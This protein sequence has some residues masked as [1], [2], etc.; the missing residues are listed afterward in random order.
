[1]KNK[2]AQ[3]SS[4][5]TAR[6]LFLAN[7][8][9]ELRTPIQTIIGTM[10]LLG[11]TQLDSEQNE[12]VRQVRFSADVLLSLVNDFLDF[13]KLESGKFRL[14]YIPYNPL[15]LV[16]Q[17]VDLLA[18]EAYNKKIEIITDIDYSLP[19]KIIGDPTRVQQILLNL[20]KNA[21]KFTPSGYVQIS[22]KADKAKK[23]ITYE[24]KD[25]GIG[26]KKEEQKNLFTDFYQTD[27][28]T[29]RKYGGTGLGLAICKNF[30]KLMKGN[31]GMHDNPDGGSIFSFSLPYDDTGQ[32]E[33]KPVVLGDDIIKNK[34]ILIVDDQKI[35]AE[36]FIKKL[37]FLGFDSIEAVYSGEE[38]LDTMLSAVNKGQPFTDVFIDMIMPN[39]DGWRLSAEINQNAI[40]NNAKLFLLIPEGQMDGEAKMK[41]LKW[42]NSY[43]HKPIK[44]D[45][46]IN[47]LVDSAEDILELEVVNQDVEINTVKSS[48]EPI[49]A[50]RTIL[51]AEDHPVN[52]KLIKTFF[53]QFGANVI[54]AGNGEE[55][56]NLLEQNPNVDLVFMDIQ[57]PV[58]SGIDATKEIRAKGTQ[59]PII[60][61]TANT[62]EADFKEYFAV[63]MNDILLK[64]FKKKNVYEL[65]EKWI[66]QLSPVEEVQEV[67]A[68]PETKTQLPVWDIPSMQNMLGYDNML[69]K[70]LVQQFLIQSMQLIHSAEEAAEKHDFVQI[71]KNAEILEDSA[72]VLSAQRIADDAK[73]LFS[74][75]EKADI[76]ACNLIIHK[77]KVSYSEF[78][79]LAENWI[80]GIKEQ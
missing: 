27:A 55:A 49:A 60:A 61:C 18:I 37:E 4:R 75:A 21:V 80:E 36:S 73:A 69:T 3:D 71:S 68:V 79:K 59:V 51:I 56:V 45:A 48:F 6:N 65:L 77:C 20:I 70:E 10:E 74:K 12:Y 9:H 62:D 52:Q 44:K 22:V 29:T 43:L 26:I 47:L 76:T 50:G 30:V 42:F 57:M 39:M 67:V 7:I 35:S 32:T 72:K 66:E 28:S 17:T 58:K 63:G 38:A 41:R 11:E 19:E 33:N 46:L 40:I 1:M 54:C 53:T 23:T 34:R 8:T 2:E 24:V 15:Q 13:S 25:S 64:P 31:I 78:A 5:E 14:E 16:E